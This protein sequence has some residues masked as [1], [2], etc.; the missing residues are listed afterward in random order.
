M[1]SHIR[2]ILD[3]AQ[4]A[5]LAEWRIK[6][7]RTPNRVH[8][9]A[10]GTSPGR[11]LAW[12]RQLNHLQSPCGCEQ[13]AVGLY[14]GVVGYLVFLLLRPGGWGHPG[15]PG[16]WV[17]LG[18]VLVTTSTAKFLG[19]LLTRRKLRRLIRVIQSEWKPQSAPERR[20]GPVFAKPARRPGG[21]CGD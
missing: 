15:W 16:F 8:L 4:L 10:E 19:I 17:G 5:A 14:V 7:P 6:P 11:V 12:E 20:Q 2:R 1:S 13:G 3:P 21:C 9:E 18:V